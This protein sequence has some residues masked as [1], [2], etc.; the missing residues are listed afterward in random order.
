MNSIRASV[1]DYLSLRRS[2]GFK[3]SACGRALRDF[4]EYMERRHA[5]FITQELALAWAEQPQDVQQAYYA[6]RLGYVRVFARYRSAI[7]PRTQVP[8]SGLLPFRPRR[9]R[10][11]IFSEDEIKGLLHAAIEMKFYSSKEALQPQLFHCMFGLLAV[12]G[13]RIGEVCNLE[14]RNVDLQDRVLTV[15]GTKFGKSRLVPLHPSANRVLARYVAQ[16]ARHFE[17]KQISPYVFVTNRGNHLD[18]GDVHRTFYR[19]LEAIGLGKDGS[20]RRP[21]IHDL[22]HTFAMRTLVR[23]YQ[24]GRDPQLCLPILSTYLGHTTSSDTQWYLTNAPELMSTAMRRLENRW[25][26]QP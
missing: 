1:E 2:F 17:G 25:E 18:S 5:K 13:M 10:P 20:R 15:L 19:L 9:P 8:A 14:L 16:R 11:Y 6:L 3:L 4:A 22:R 21:R 7:D 23:W 24:D 26:A 12:T